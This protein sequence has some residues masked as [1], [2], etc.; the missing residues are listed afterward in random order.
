M[1]NLF[2]LQCPTCGATLQIAGE[3][4]R[5]ICQ[6]CHNSYLLDHKIEEMSAAERE[7][8]RPT[9]TYTKQTR[10]WIRVAS[11]DVFLHAI[12]EETIKKE[13]VLYIDVEYRNQSSEPLTCRHDQWVVFDS[14]GYTYEPV[15]DFSMPELYTEK[16][17][18][19]MSRIITPG[20]KLRGWLA[21]VLPG[22]AAIEYVQFSGGVPAKT[23]EFRL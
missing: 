21:F 19:G 3:N 1:T 4:N 20:M 16:R 17:Y 6:H 14:N 7:D 22:P 8:I 23:V 11:Y 2:S 9:A 10:Q 13:R 15:K 5:F 12:L 18:L